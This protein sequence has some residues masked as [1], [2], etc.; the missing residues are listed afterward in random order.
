MILL[1]KVNKRSL[2]SDPHKTG[3]VNPQKRPMGL[4]L[5][6]RLQ[7]QVLREFAQEK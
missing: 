1:N 7:L 6:F 5:N 4:I 3:T 2:Q